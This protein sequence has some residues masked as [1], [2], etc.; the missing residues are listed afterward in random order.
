MFQTLT[1]IAE[2]LITNDQPNNYQEVATSWLA[3]LF[4]IAASWMTVMLLAEIVQRKRYS[5]ERRYMWGTMKTLGWIALGLVPVLVTVC[6]VFFNSLDF[7]LVV[8]QPG[9]YKGIFL[10]GLIYVSMML[11]G[12]LFGNLRRDLYHI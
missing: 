11:A 3:A 2:W 8:G 5:D 10:A 9:L 12:H 7:Q 1:R 4:I 6:V